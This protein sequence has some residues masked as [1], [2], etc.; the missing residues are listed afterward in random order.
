MKHGLGSIAFSAALMLTACGQ[1]P[2]FSD[3]SQGFLADGSGAGTG[4]GSGA[5]SGTGSV[6]SGDAVAQTAPEKQAIIP[7]SDI[8][9]PKIGGR[10]PVVPQSGGA[11][12]TV[13]S[14]PP[15]PVFHT[16]PSNP[17]SPVFSVPGATTAEAEQITAC[18]RKWGQVPFSGAIG[19]RRIRAAVT[20]GG[21]GVAVNDATQTTGPAL[22]LVDAGVNVGG[23]PV[24]NM[25]NNNGYYCMKVNVNVST[26]LTV[27]LAC[28]ARLAD[29]S[30][31]VNVGSSV[32]GTTS[33]I[34]VNVN[35]NVSVQR[36]TPGGA[37]CQ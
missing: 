30:V 28:N 1:D 35:S 21:F 14:V 4:E 36:L 3:K 16:N 11:V 7:G 37:A 13:A 17:A 12:P 15:A 34:G 33:G 18:L 8:P 27:N 23:A 32:A 26:A 24:Y 22:I 20:V 31:Q 29:N 10:A 9:V 5:V 6:P 25:L 2:A 19:V